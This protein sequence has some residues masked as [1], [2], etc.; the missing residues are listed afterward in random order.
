M[1]YF[2]L[3]KLLDWLQSRCTHPDYGVKADILEGGHYC[4]VQWCEICGAFRFTDY[5][6]VTAAGKTFQP[7]DNEWRR[8]QPM[9][10]LRRKRST[11]AYKKVARQ[12]KGC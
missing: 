1:I 6:K 7:P 2:L 4:R 9:W 3:S 12:S 5:E 10:V 11:E 8:P